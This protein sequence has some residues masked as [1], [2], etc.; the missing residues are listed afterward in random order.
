MLISP[1][2]VKDWDCTAHRRERTN[3]LG[4]GVL[5]SGSGLSGGGSS[6]SIRTGSSTFSGNENRKSSNPQLKCGPIPGTLHVPQ[7]S[8]SRKNAQNTRLCRATVLLS[9]SD[10]KMT[11]LKMPKTKKK[12]WLLSFLKC[13]VTVFLR[14]SPTNIYFSFS[15]MNLSLRPASG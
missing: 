10:T 1:L 7:D 12:L 14:Q 11:G 3:L 6:I 2:S 8:N 13:T 9:C 5:G 15:G 4:S